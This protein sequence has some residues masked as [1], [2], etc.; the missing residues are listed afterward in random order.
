[1]LFVVRRRGLPKIPNRMTSSA[2]SGEGVAV[3]SQQLYNFQHTLSGDNVRNHSGDPILGRLAQIFSAAQETS[4]RNLGFKSDL[5]EG[6]TA[7]GRLVTD[8]CSAQPTLRVLLPDGWQETLSG[9]PEVR[10]ALQEALGNVAS[11]HSSVERLIQGW[12]DILSVSGL[13]RLVSDGEVVEIDAAQATATSA[14][15]PRRGTQP[16]SESA[17]KTA[18]ATDSVPSHARLAAE[19]REA[20]GLSA[21]KLAAAFGVTREQ[22]SRW[23]NGASIS[24]ARHGQL[25]YLHTVVADLVRRLG[26]VSEA[27]V[28]LHT[29][30]HS[31]ETPGEL[32]THRRWGDLY[33]LVTEV[34]DSEPLVD[35]VRVA[36][37][38]PLT[39]E[40][41][42][43]AESDEVDGEGSWS[44]YA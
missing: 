2:G 9:E 20:T 3:A 12:G 25:R 14:G 16:N 30:L 10:A 28:W 34:P 4:Y 6:Q 44:P 29:P 27:R 15:A 17:E 19:L 13:L 7:L 32:L 5:F 40:E 36:L 35:G 11:G 38:A 26:S 1:M 18:E 31:G 39:E 8:A 37:L 33:R 24:D 23:V 22:Y 42:N 21:A 41:E 43:P